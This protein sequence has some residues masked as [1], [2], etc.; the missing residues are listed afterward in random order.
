MLPNCTQSSLVYEN[1]CG[2]C[3]PGAEEGKELKEVKHDIPTLCVYERS[4]EHWGA[5]RSRSEKSHIWKHQVEAHKGAAP[6]FYMRVVRN[7]KSALSRQIFEAVRIRRRGGAGSILNSKAEYDRCRIP[8]LIVEEQDLDGI[9]KEEEQ[10]IS[11]NSEALEEQE[12]IWG[13]QRLLEREQED[14]EIRKSIPKIREK[15]K[16]MKREQEDDREQRTSPDYPLPKTRSSPSHHQQ[17]V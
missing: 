12:I 3:N 15:S 9:T 13:S 6:K 14:R 1:V 17:T 16:V 5:W 8:R 7:F 4:K 10:E 11:R 2:A